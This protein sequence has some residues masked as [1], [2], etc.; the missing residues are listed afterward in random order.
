[1]LNRYKL[2]AALLLI[3]FGIVM[4]VIPHAPNV[5]PIAA[6]ALVAG[7][8]LGRRYAIV[9]PLITMV[10]SD[11]FIGYHALA[12]VI[13]LSFA[14]VGLISFWLR[15]RLSFGNV[16]TAS[17]AGSIIFFL[18]TNLAVWLY[19]PY[20]SLDL[21]GLLYCFYLALPFFR[22]TVMGD[23]GFVAVLFA[24]AETV[25]LLRKQPIIEKLAV[26]KGINIPLG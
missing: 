18:I 16:I 7:V 22:N 4:R 8:Y 14:L 20:Y 5:A 10:I 13:W 21:S 2:L 17:L 25:L 12:P 3:I 19:V 24:I 1:M 11:I 26:K 6:I 9:L 15:G 23:L